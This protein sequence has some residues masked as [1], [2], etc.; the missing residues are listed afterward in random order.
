MKLGS[1]WNFVICRFLGMGEDE[2][3]G[4]LTFVFGRDFVGLKKRNM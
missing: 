2:V 3:P 4:F 1:G